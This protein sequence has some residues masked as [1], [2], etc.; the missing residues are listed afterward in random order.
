MTASSKVS[1]VTFLTPRERLGIKLL[2]RSKFRFAL[3]S[4]L[5]A[6]PIIASSGF[7]VWLYSQNQALVSSAREV[8]GELELLDQEIEVLSRRA[9]LP[10]VRPNSQSSNALGPISKGQ[11]G[12]PVELEAKTQLKLAQQKLPTLAKRLQNETRPALEKTLQQEEV[13]AQAT[14]T[15]NPVK[16]SFEVSSDFG[17]RPNPYGGPGY[18][19]HDG[20]DILGDHGTPIYATASGHAERAQYG[21]GYGYHVVLKN[22]QGYET[23][24]AHLS[25]LAVTPNEKVKQGQLIGYMGSTGR[26]TGTHLHYSIYRNGKAIDPKTYMGKDWVYSEAF[27]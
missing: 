23:L 5:V 21:G 8:V 18:E 11:G 13:I 2:V 25:K 26:S 22:S 6:T 4:C 17:I 12:V 20:I 7:A 1:K 15:G 10:R 27:N 9:G 3:I 14:P 16:G 24:Y 19:G